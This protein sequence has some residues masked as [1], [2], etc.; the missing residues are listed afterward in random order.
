M[1][2]TLARGLRTRLD[3]ITDRA[4]HYTTGSGLWALY[5]R[6]RHLKYH[7]YDRLNPSTQVQDL[8]DYLDTHADPIFWG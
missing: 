2:T 8:L 5:W 4:L 3:P 1:P 6:D 7:R